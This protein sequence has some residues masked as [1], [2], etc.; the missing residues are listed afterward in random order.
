MIKLIVVLIGVGTVLFI[1]TG[2]L[3]VVLEYTGV[4]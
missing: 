4:R 3:E 1:L 2:I